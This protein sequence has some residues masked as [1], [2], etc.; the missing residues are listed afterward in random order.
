MTDQ[1]EPTQ[2]CAGCGTLVAVRYAD[3]HKR[4]GCA[5]RIN[6]TLRQYRESHGGVHASIDDTIKSFDKD[7]DEVFKRLNTID[8]RDEANGQ[9]GITV[10]G[11]LDDDLDDLDSDDLEPA[12]AARH[13]LTDVQPRINPVTGLPE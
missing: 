13:P 11:D 2:F 12:P 9:A 4:Q 3:T 7:I 5:A 6:N 1:L 8:D 10:T